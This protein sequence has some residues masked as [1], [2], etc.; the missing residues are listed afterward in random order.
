[1]NEPVIVGTVGKPHGLRGEVLVRPRTDEVAERFAAGASLRVGEQELEVSG[2][3]L[4]QGRL[5]VRFA[6]VSDR[7]SAEALRGLDVWAK[8]ASEA[9]DEDEFHDLE[10]IGLR[11]EDL[12]GA[13]LGRVIAIQHHPAQDLL[14]IKTE[15]G[16]RL[17]PFVAA[18]VPTVDPAAGRLV[19][20]PIPGLMAEL[21]DAD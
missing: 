13:E 1:M 17:V 21:P 2:H 6:G 15:S 9:T 14:V 10:L 16:E 19:V 4:Q 3:S 18:L 5:V 11:V 12:A 7:S 20:N 8:I